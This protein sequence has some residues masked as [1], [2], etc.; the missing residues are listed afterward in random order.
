MHC[1][2]TGLR[3]G[4]LDEQVGQTVIVQTGEWVQYSS[5]SPEGAEYIDVC[6]SLPFRWIPVIEMIEKG[7]SLRKSR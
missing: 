7:S 1:D 6:A 5:P 3:D 4:D 2:L